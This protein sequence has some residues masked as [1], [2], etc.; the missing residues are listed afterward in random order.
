HTGIGVPVDPGLQH[1]VARVVGL[2]AEGPGHRGPGALHVQ[3]GQVDDPG[4]AFDGDDTVDLLD[5]LVGDQAGANIPNPVRAA[6]GGH[7]DVVDVRPAKVVVEPLDHPVDGVTPRRVNPGVA[8]QVDR[9]GPVRCGLDTGG[10]RDL[11]VGVGGPAGADRAV[12]PDEGDLHGGRDAGCPGG[13]D[14]GA[15]HD[16]HQ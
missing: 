10:Q 2:E 6:G 7:T 9:P 8:D 14:G 15:V 13:S 12:Q 16:G 4:P 1:D 5:G 11:L 3:V